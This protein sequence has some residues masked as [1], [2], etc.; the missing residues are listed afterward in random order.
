MGGAPMFL[1]MGATQCLYNVTPA[2]PLDQTIDANKLRLLVVQKWLFSRRRWEDLLQHPPSICRFE[3]LFTPAVS[4]LP[5]PAIMFRRQWL[6]RVLHPNKRGRITKLQLLVYT[7]LVRDKP[8]S[9]LPIFTC[10]LY[11]KICL[12]DGKF[13]LPSPYHYQLTEN[14][15]RKQLNSIRVHFFAGNQ[16]WSIRGNTPKFLYVRHRALKIVAGET[17]ERHERLSL[18]CWSLKFCYTPKMRRKQCV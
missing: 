4:P 10:K 17:H 13:V 9:Q 2:G 11:C 7:S 3:A 12:H 1:S 15:C 18:R 8:I 6:C 5:P 16:R 14:V